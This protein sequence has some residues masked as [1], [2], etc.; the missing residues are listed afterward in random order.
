MQQQLNT[1]SEVINRNQQGK[2][3]TMND[4]A[5]RLTREQVLAKCENALSKMSENSLG[6]VMVLFPGRENW[7]KYYAYLRDS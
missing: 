2:G 4:L 6:D 3:L 1:K 7:E 5:A